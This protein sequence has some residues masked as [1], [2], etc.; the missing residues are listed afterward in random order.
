MI[1]TAVVTVIAAYLIGSVNFAVIF[2]RLFTDRD[3]RDF[4]SGNAGATN[5]LRVAGIVPGL[6]TFLCDVLK[7]LLACTLGHYIFEYMLK[8]GINWAMPIYGAYLCGLACMVGHVFPIFFQ[9]KGGKG[10]AISVGIYLI[11]ST[12]AIIIGLL[13][14]AVMVL[15][16]RIVSAS[17]LLATVVVVVFSFVFRDSVAEATPQILM[18]LAMGTIIFLR[19]ASNIQRL[20]NG[21]EKKLNFKGM[22]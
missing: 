10:V 2:T 12:P 14:F 13:F 17:S 8:Q 18:S 6:L 22:S 3:V 7:G 16:T 21:E 5:T 4:G 15:L 19:H 9:F 20:L 1:M 11:C